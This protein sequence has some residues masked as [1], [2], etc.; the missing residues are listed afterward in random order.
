MK[1]TEYLS[2]GRGR[3][4]ALAASI[5]VSTAFVSLMA[6]GKRKVPPAMAVQI[7][8]ATEGAVTRKDLRPDDWRV[9]WPEL[10]G[11]VR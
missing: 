8:Q 3:M 1:L 9:L 10:V 6:S 4:S 5:E 11:G 7:E 2:G